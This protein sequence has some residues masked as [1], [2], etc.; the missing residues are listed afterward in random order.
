MLTFK[1]FQVKTDY[2]T[3]REQKEAY[4]WY[5]FGCKQGWSDCLTQDETSTSDYFEQAD[6][7]GE[8]KC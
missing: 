6:K 5:L 8:V 7:Y 1:E 2:L 3:Y 4:D